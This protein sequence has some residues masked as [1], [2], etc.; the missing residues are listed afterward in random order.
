MCNCAY[1][2]PLANDATPA[3]TNCLLN[4]IGLTLLLNWMAMLVRNSDMSL[5]TPTWLYLGWLT[6]LSTSYPL[7]SLKKWWAPTKVR[8]D[9]GLVLIVHWA[10]LITQR[11]LMR[12]P[13]QL[14]R[15]PVVQFGQSLPKLRQET[16]Y[17]NC[18]GL[19]V[20]PLMMRSP[21]IFSVHRSNPKLI[22]EPKNRATTTSPMISIQTNVSSLLYQRKI[23]K[24]LSIISKI[25][26]GLNVF[27]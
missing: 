23:R 16:M 20:E 13:P 22:D 15:Q 21:L 17:G 10:A 19:A 6:T 14:W 7:P 24:L 12:L 5:R 1:P 26:L 18:P 3:P 8:T 4:E 27:R 9:L 11:L 2:H 25:T